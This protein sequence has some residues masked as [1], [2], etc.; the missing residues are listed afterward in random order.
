MNSNIQDTEKDSDKRAPFSMPAVIKPRHLVVSRFIA[1]KEQGSSTRWE[2][3]GT[4]NSSLLLRWN[5]L[6]FT[7][8]RNTLAPEHPLLEIQLLCH[9]TLN[10]LKWFHS[11]SSGHLNT[12]NQVTSEKKCD[13]KKRDQRIQQFFPALGGSQVHFNT[14]VWVQSIAPWSLPQPQITMKWKAK[15]QKTWVLSVSLFYCTTFDNH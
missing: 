13:M 2:S 9:R 14:T 10:C 5:K 15:D 12:Y 6:P 3:A 1:F 7:P 11:K 8:G 4:V